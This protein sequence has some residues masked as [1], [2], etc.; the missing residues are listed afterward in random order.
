MAKV[1]SGA[2]MMV[3]TMYAEVIMVCCM[4]IGRAMC[5][6]RFTTCHVG[7]KR[8]RSILSDSSLLRKQSMYIV[9][10]AATSSAEAVPIAAPTT[11]MPA[12]GSVSD[13][14][15]TSTVRVWKM[16]K[17]LNTTSSDIITTLIMLGTSMLPELRSMPWLNI[18][19]WNAGIAMAMMA[20]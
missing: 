13:T 10:D 14:P 5:R 1:P 16:R 9:M 6:A 8:P 15:S 4:P 19:N 7:R 3:V 11:P 12:P 2:M 18:E 17:K 20:K